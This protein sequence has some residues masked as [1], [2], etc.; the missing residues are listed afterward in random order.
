M[1][2]EFDAIK[3]PAGFIPLYDD[4]SSLFSQIFDKT[5]SEELY[6][7]LFSIRVDK[8]LRRLDRMEKIYGEESDIPQVFSDEIN[9]QRER[10]NAAKNEYNTD[11]ISPINFL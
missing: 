7:R 5:F 3:T 8:L 10:L 9:S 4:L 2:N 1:H 11:V 6:E